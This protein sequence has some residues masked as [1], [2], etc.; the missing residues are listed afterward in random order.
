MRSLLIIAASLIVVPS[1]SAALG[2]AITTGSPVTAP[3][4]TLTGIDQTKTFTIVTS[5]T[6]GGAAGWNETAL[7][8]I[9]TVGGNV[10]PALIVT[11]VTSTGGLPGPTN[12]ITWPITLT[13][14]AAKV[15]NAAPN[16]GKATITTTHTLKITYP[17]NALPG[18]YASVITFAIVAGP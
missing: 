6:G 2:V 11:G 7:A 5:I 9:P 12:S 3:G 17:S 16:T 4:V 15:F 14:T 8:T 13:T 18:I 1:A 10:L